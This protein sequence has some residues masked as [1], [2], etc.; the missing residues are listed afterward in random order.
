MKRKMRM[1]WFTAFVPETLYE[2][3]VSLKLSMSTSWFS[4]GAE[5]NPGVGYMVKWL[6]PTEKL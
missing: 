2:T 5:G 4:D 3:I 6:L 1:T